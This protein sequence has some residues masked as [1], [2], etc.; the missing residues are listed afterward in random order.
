MTNNLTKAEMLREIDAVVAKAK[1]IQ[2]D[3]ARLEQ[4]AAI[5]RPSIDSGWIEQ[6]RGTEEHYRDPAIL[7]RN[8]PA[9]QMALVVGSQV[10]LIWERHP[11]GKAIPLTMTI[12]GQRY[13]GSYTIAASQARAIREGIQLTDAKV[14]RDLTLGDVEKIY[15]DEAATSSPV[16]LLEERLAN[17]REL[18]S[19]L[20]EEFDG[21]FL[22]VLKRAD[23]RLYREDG[24]GLIQILE[25]RF[26]KSFG[27]WPMAKLPQVMAM[28]LLDQRD[29]GAFDPE[30][31]SLLD[32]EDLAELE[33]GADY[34][35]PWFFIRVGLFAISDELKQ[36]LRDHQLIEPGS[37]ME[38]E[39]RAFT[40][41][42]MREIGA[43]MKGWPASARELEIETH[44]QAF[45]RC[46]RCQVGISEAELPC[47]YRGIC[48]ATH[49]DNEL[50][51]CVWPL[52]LTTEY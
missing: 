32:F 35:R 30:I 6:Y 17:Y 5:A 7:L 41:K 34:Y 45:L 19:V 26:P 40:I 33:G 38:L 52:V 42:A 51:D 14:L 2:I 39:F 20:L 29:A 31:S 25:T 48:K 23:R 50:M 16:Q 24:N 22:N 36:L 46:R 4:V 49:E 47:P 13:V 8:E 10:W 27:D 43:R 28:S 12:E 18:G 9:L 11:G 37:D 3:R 15:R 44:A 21:R 1:H